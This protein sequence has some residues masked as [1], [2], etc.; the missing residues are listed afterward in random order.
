[1]RFGPGAATSQDEDIAAR[2]R[3]HRFPQGAP[4][5]KVRV[6]ERSPTVEQHQIDVTRQLQVLKSVI[7]NDHIRLEVFHGQHSDI[8]AFSTDHDR[9]RDTQQPGGQQVGFV[10]CGRA[11]Q[12]DFSP[13]ADDAAVF[14]GAALVSP[15]DDC[16][17]PSRALQPLGQIEGHGRFS[18][19]ACGNVSDG[20]HFAG[21]LP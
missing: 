3:R 11:C 8:I 1:M 4:R 13:I 19:T 9:H 21:Q 17:A 10:P 18:G 14:F 5:K 15:A 6:A 16:R 20:D 12:D 2:K 7:E